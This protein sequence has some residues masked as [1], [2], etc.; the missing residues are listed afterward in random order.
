LV[1]PGDQSIGCLQSS[2]PDFTGYATA[3]DDCDLN[4]TPTFADDESGY[5]ATHRYGMIVRTWMVTDSGGNSVFADQKI[6]VVDA[7]PPEITCPPDFLGICGASLD[8]ADTGGMATATDIC[9]LS[10]AIS[11]TDTIVGACPKQIDRVWT[12]SDGSGHLQQC[13]QRLFFSSQWTHEYH[14]DR[15]W[16]LISFPG[17]PLPSSI[18]N[19][20]ERGLSALWAWQDDRLARFSNAIGIEGQRGYWIYC[21]NPVAITIQGLNPLDARTQL[22]DDLIGVSTPVANLYDNLIVENPIWQWGNSCYSVSGDNGALAPFI[23][24]WVYAHDEGVIP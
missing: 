24:Y 18:E 8:P 6:T 19:L 13:T 15:G 23:G 3:T 12:A 2:H 17:P 21:F 7:N 22:Q 5:H 16:N 9:D 14:L 11:Y 20:F 10:P 1:V 4:L